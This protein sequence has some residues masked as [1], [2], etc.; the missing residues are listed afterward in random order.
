MSEFIDKKRERVLFMVEEVDDLNEQVKTLALN[1]AIYLAKARAEGHSEELV[2]ME[3][4]FVRL[5]N[6]TVK[7][8]Q[9]LAVVLNAARN[10]E[11]MVY[12]VPSNQRDL[13]KIEFGLRTVL[14][15]CS[16]IMES[17]AKARDLTGQA[18]AEE[19]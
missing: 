2:K 19:Q 4:D 10:K 7:V 18:P 8:V 1:L 13:D 9:E 15:Q 3:P 6:R 5:V 11:K 12:E 16:R 17:L 14:D